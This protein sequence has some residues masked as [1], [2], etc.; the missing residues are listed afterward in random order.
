[1]VAPWSPNVEVPFKKKWM[2]PDRL[3]YLMGFEL[4]QD[5]S[6][7]TRDAN[8]IDNH[9]VIGDHSEP[10]KICVTSGSLKTF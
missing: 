4:D 7:R 2:A 10:P 1:M 5:P 9:S 6:L 3:Q 8:L